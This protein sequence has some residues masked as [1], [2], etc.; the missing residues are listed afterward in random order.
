GMHGS[1]GPDGLPGGR[2]ASGAGGFPITPGTYYVTHG[3]LVDYKRVDLLVQAF[4][5]LG[6]P[7]L[8]IGDGPERRRL[9]ALAGPGIRFLGAVDD[10]ALPGYVANARA[11]VFAADEDFGIAPVEAQAAGCPVVAYSR[12][13][14]AETVVEGRT[15]VFFHEQTV[16]A[17]AGAV[18]RFEAAEAGFDRAAIMEHAARFGPERFRSEFAGL[19]DRAWHAFLRRGSKGVGALP[20]PVRL[21]ALSG[22]MGDKPA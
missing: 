18:R 5:R 4:N 13:G 11:F 9:Q 19:L 20:E 8:V 1:P 15:G 17:V 12:G 14:A 16:E 21:A 3:R 6:R 22:P 7:L 10:E 2:D